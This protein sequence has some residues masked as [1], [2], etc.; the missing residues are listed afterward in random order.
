LLEFFTLGSQLLTR[1]RDWIARTVNVE[2]GDS[3][4]AYLF[5]SEIPK[6]KNHPSLSFL[7]SAIYIVAKSS[8]ITFACN[9]SNRRRIQSGASANKGAESKMC[10]S[11][12][13]FPLDESLAVNPFFW[14]PE[15]C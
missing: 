15:S 11:M 4:K 9:N 14:R 10:L 5:I 13:R 8:C 7:S 6:P 2:K 1:V 3:K 12:L